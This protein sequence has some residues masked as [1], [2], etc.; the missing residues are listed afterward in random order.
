MQSFKN[1]VTQKMGRI[2]QRKD[3]KASVGSTKEVKLSVG[4]TRE[5]KS[6][7]LAIFVPI[8]SATWFCS[9]GSDVAQIV[10]Q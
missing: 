9:S 3:K 2:F 1:C 8:P 4:S 5:I 7:T 10:F 6:I